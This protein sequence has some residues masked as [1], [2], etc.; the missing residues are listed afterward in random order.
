MVKRN[1][2]EKKEVIANENKIKICLTCHGKNIIREDKD[3]SYL[4]WKKYY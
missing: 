4:S 1:W 2:G 3:L